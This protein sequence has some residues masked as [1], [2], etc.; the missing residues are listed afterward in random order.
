MEGGNVI[1]IPP[2]N[3]TT[4]EGEIA[5]F[6]CC[7]K[8]NTSNVV[9]KKDGV[10]LSHKN[11]NFPER[12]SLD[13]EGTLTISPTMMDDSGEFT[14]EATNYKGEKQSASAFLNVQCKKRKFFKENL[15]QNHPN[16][17]N[18][19]FFFFYFR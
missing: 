9:W 4:I 8:E 1:A 11:H 14:C 13:T 5:R 10:R 15:R 17:N 19:F 12:Y 7:T 3:Q 6:P 18:Q 16:F 2:I